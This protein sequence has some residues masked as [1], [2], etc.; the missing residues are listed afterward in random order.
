MCG[1][2][3]S[4]SFTY[5]RA[6]DRWLVVHACT[7][8]C[9]TACLDAYMPACRH[10]VPVAV[11]VRHPPKMGSRPRGPDPGPLLHAR[12]R[13]AA[14]RSRRSSRCCSTACTCRS[15]APN[16]SSVFSSVLA[17]LITVVRR[18]GHATRR[19]CTYPH[20]LSRF[21]SQ[22]DENCRF[23]RQLPLSQTPSVAWCGHAAPSEDLLAPRSAAFTALGAQFYSCRHLEITFTFDN[24]YESFVLVAC[25]MPFLPL[26]IEV[27]RCPQLCSVR[28]LVCRP[29]P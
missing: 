7:P 11:T 8:A 29:S 9:M 23:R 26:L 28:P 15:S 12:S 13:T 20:R 16:P 1:A 4:S 3:P 18:A 25:R 14:P 2:C 24:Q 22:I 21:R 10:P 27:P 17:R 6:D 5:A 19:G